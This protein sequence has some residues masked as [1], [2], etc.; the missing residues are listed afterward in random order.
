[1][2]WLATEAHRPPNV[3][4]HLFLGGVA[5]IFQCIWRARNALIHEKKT[6]PLP[7][8]VININTRLLELLKAQSGSTNQLSEWLSPPVGWITCNTDIAIGINRSVGAAIFRDHNSQYK[9]IYTFKCNHCDPLAGE[10][11]ALYEGAV[12]AVKHGYKNV[13][14]QSD[15]SNAIDA[16]LLNPQ[17][18]KL[19]HHNIQGIVSKFHLTVAHL[20]LWEACWIPKSC[21]SVAH[22]AA[23]GV[24]RSMAFGHFI[25]P[26]VF[27]SLQSPIVDGHDPL[28]LV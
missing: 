5:I 13:I 24:N 16:L 15:S 22:L 6:T 20:N 25:S 18:I 8:T 23:H 26:S 2:N 3:S 12:E 7:V 27:G 9:G 1:L 10:V 28:S 11:A 14:F 17:D 21:N 19:L 4:Y